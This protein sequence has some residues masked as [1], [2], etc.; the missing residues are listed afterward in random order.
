MNEPFQK[1]QIVAI[2]RADTGKVVATAQVDKI[3]DREVRT[4]TP[5]EQRATR[6]ELSRR[7]WRASDPFKEMRVPRG[8]GRPACVIRPATLEDVAHMGR[9]VEARRARERMVRNQR[10]KPACEHRIAL[11]EA[12]LRRER[13][14][15]ERLLAQM[16]RDARLIAEVGEEDRQ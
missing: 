12:A 11:A 6:H 9:V 15:Y 1:G 10:E 4:E 2:V 14:P 16:E 5:Y 7:Y 3:T 8:E 13:E